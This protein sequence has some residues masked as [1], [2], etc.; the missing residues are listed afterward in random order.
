MKSE[1]LINSFAFKNIHRMKKLFY[2]MVLVLII[3]KRNV[4]GQIVISMNR[5][6]TDGSQSLSQADSLYIQPFSEGNIGK[7]FQMGI[8]KRIIFEL[9]NAEQLREI[10]SKNKYTWVFIQSSSCGACIPS[11]K[12]NIRI[13]DSLS[14]YG[15][16]LVVINVDAHIKNLRKKIEMEKYF[17]QSYIINPA[18]YG[19]K[20][21]EKHDRFVN[22][23]VGAIEGYSPHVLPQNI[24]LDQAGKFVYYDKT[25]KINKDLII[26][27]VISKK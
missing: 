2:C 14:G 25:Y 6:G 27:N 24:F 22:D 3:N 13:A 10:C 21:V 18:E 4:N 26:N 7:K 11:L 1:G 20:E 16:K 23:L 19:I 8:N 12:K 9:I 5:D 17:T 15:V